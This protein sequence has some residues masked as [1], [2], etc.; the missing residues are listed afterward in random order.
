MVVVLAGSVMVVCV[1][2]EGVGAGVM[3]ESR[4]VG[5]LIVMVSATQMAR[6][7][8]TASMNTSSSH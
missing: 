5:G 6:K 8:T 7:A 4:A 2:L 1:V 3:S